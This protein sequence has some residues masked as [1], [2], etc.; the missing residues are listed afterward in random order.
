MS[1]MEVKYR[2]ELERW[3]P[4]IC[5]KL[6]R[7]RGERRSELHVVLVTDRPDP[8]RSCFQLLRLGT[9]VPGEPPVTLDL[10]EADLG[11][12][13]ATVEKY[14]P[15]VRAMFEAMRHLERK[16]E[17][18]LPGRVSLVADQSRGASLG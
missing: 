7:E 18:K 10:H 3:L 14:E 4:H 17:V 13:R 12:H 16:P 6:I 5:E 2:G 11:I 1:W 9:Y 8:G 15:F